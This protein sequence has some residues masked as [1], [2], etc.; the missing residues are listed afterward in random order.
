M[1]D[2]T[3]QATPAPQIKLFVARIGHRQFTAAVS[4]RPADSGWL[5][6]DVKGTRKTAI[7]SLEA[8]LREAG[9]TVPTWTVVDKG[10][11]TAKPAPTPAPQPETAAAPAAQPTEPVATPAPTLPETEQDAIADNAEEALEAAVVLPPVAPKMDGGWVTPLSDKAAWL[12]VYRQ[13]RNKFDSVDFPGEKR[14]EKIANYRETINVLMERYSFVGPWRRALGGDF[15][16]RFSGEMDHT[17]RQPN[18]RGYRAQQF[19][20]DING[21]WIRIERDKRDP[22][23]LAVPPKPTATTQEARDLIAKSW[24]DERGNVTVEQ[25]NPNGGND[26]STKAER[27]AAKDEKR[28]LNR[29]AHAAQRKAEKRTYTGGTKEQRNLANANARSYSAA[30]AEAGHD[31]STRTLWYKIGM[32]VSLRSQGVAE[33]HHFE[34]DLRAAGYSDADIA[35]YVEGADSTA[36]AA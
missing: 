9:A 12:D 19:A 1:T 31:R 28:A 6:S 32:V 25:D 17:I 23:K 2:L 34:D 22:A 30:A 29:A 3:T 16:L 20:K 35:S 33:P 5:V 18:N 7:A 24:D 13:A 14:W 4:Y 27:K 11:L 36:K 21:N 8:K 10:D 15:W 26:V